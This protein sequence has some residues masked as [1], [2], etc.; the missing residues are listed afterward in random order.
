MFEGIKVRTPIEILWGDAW[1][2]DKRYFYPDDPEGD[3]GPKRVRT[4]GYFCREIEDAVV[5]AWSAFDEKEG[6]DRLQSIFSIPKSWVI[7][8]WEIKE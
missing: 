1:S 5:I 4:M 3:F 8:W 6:D 7:D 2:N